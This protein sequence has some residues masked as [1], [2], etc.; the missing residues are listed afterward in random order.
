[1]SALENKIP[2]PLIGVIIGAAM[3]VVAHFVPASRWEGAWHFLLA[4]AG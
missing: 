4:G 3:A 1:M 2:P